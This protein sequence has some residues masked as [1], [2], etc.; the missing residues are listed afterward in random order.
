MLSRASRLA[1]VLSAIVLFAAACKVDTV[2]LPVSSGGTGGIGTT[3]ASVTVTLGAASISN[4]G[5]TTATATVTDSIGRVVPN[6]TVSFSV[7]S[8]TAGSFSPAAGTTD[9]N[10]QLAAT[11]TAAAAGN[12]SNVTIRAS[13]ATGTG[14]ISGSASL[15]IGTPP[16]IPTTITVSLSTYTVSSGSGAVTV[17]ATVTGAGSTPVS[18]AT[19]NFAVSDATA[20]TFTGGSNT[21]AATT[22]ASGVATATFNANNAGIIVQISAT[23]GSLTNSGTLTI[24]TP[25]PPAAATLNLTAS[26]AQ[27]SIQGQ[28][29]I[30]VSLLSSSGAAVFST[31]V[32][33]TITTGATLGSFSTSTLVTATTVTTDATGNASAIFYAG[34]ASGL[35]T[36]TATSGS[37][38]KTV[39]I[40]LT[41]DPASISLSIADTALVNGQNTN[42]TA[43]VLNA[44]NQPV[45]IGTTVTFTI[46][47]SGSLA[48]GS[49]SSTTAFT[50]ASGDAS[51]TFTADAVNTGPVFVTAT[52]G[53]VTSSVQ[54]I[55]VDPASA[56]TLL[57]VSAD[58]PLI[59]IAGSGTTSDSVVKFQVL[60]SVGAPMANQSVDFS[61]ITGPVGATLDT[62]GT[63]VSN[64][65]TDADGYVSTTLHAGTVPGSVRIVATTTVSTVPLV[66]LSTT[67]AA[68]AIGGGVPSY[69][70]FSLSVE[71]FNIPG[72]HCDNVTSTIYVNMADRFGNYNILKG[73]TVNFVTPY[74]AINAFNYTNDTGQ[75]ESV[76]RSQSPKPTDG[77][78]RVLVYATGEERFTDLNADGVYT[79]GTDTM[80][81]ADDLPEPFKDDDHDGLHDATEMW[82]QWPS[83]VSGATTG[84]DG[85]NNV[86][87]SSTYIW[88]TVDLWLTG[89]PSTSGPDPSRV[90]CCDPAALPTCNLTQ[91]NISLNKGTS[92]FCFVYAA[93][94]NGNA[95]AGDTKVTLSSDES[96]A[97]I[98]WVSGYE[99]VPDA[100]SGGPAITGY[101]VTNNNSGT[102]A[103]F[104]TLSTTIDW[105]APASNCAGSKVTISYPGIVTLLP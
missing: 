47:Y 105:P 69:T 31:G 34:T 24:G 79:S 33:L 64:G 80:S 90:E 26:P 15:T 41:S 65:S 93:D 2:N 78:V 73:T 51:V 91:S 43:K 22:N 7:I 20:G 87:D 11:F 89:P 88:K 6:A 95:L 10:G 14:T 25:A 60:N 35:V 55:Q 102:A 4:G 8:S 23:V 61:I 58:P 77:Q 54:I 37:L 53:T 52:A 38:S 99:T 75:T 76:F 18:G 49:L 5:S 56:G 46:T 21:V 9:T 48:P 100:Q 68:V 84:Y 57:F 45:S 94:E 96:S 30:S 92:T 12:D 36:I 67:A 1:I 101:K 98:T 19:V 40:V 83:T 86:W 74:G 97:K 42:I 62:S 63:G 16:V 27:V 104:A 28:S 71:K 3:P 29:T 13:V 70:W 17:T 50:V 59:G 85:A 72:L 44:A 39:S 103:L 81:S 66:Q 32:D 82:I